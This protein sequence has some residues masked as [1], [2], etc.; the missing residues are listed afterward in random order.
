[1]QNVEYFQQ[2]NITYLRENH[3]DHS[4]ILTQNVTSSLFQCMRHLQAA[5]KNTM[6]PQYSQIEQI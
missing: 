3:S 4:D 1:M 2:K 5:S 6:S